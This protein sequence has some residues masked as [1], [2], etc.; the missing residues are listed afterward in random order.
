MKTD[1]DGLRGPASDRRWPPIEVVMNVAG[2]P[3]S[4]NRKREREVDPL[5][6]DKTAIAPSFRH[7]LGSSSALTGAAWG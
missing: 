5:L 7:P 1:E 2:D 6:N 4:T 3:A